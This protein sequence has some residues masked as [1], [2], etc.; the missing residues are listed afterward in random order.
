MEQPM[1]EPGSEKSSDADKMDA[2]VMEGGGGAALIIG[3]YDDG[4][5]EE[6]VPNFTMDV[7]TTIDFHNFSS[8]PFW[9]ASNVHPAHNILPEFDSRGPVAPGESY[10]YTFDKAGTWP[11]HDHLRASLGGVIIVTE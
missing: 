1:E 5:R 3:Y 6:E 2:E 10:R 9:P 8:R 4:F 11:F 7:G